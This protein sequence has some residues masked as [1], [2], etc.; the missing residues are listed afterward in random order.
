MDS[1]KAEPET[2]LWRKASYSV[3]NG[4]CVEVSSADCGILVRDSTIHDGP[5]LQYPA[6]TWRSFLLEIKTRL[7]YL[8]RRDPS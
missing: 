2:S 7:H 6:E 4:A 5:I 3:G 1:V 8:K